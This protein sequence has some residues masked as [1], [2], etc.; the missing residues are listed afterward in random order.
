LSKDAQVI[1]SFIFFYLDLFITCLVVVL[2]G[3]GG[4]NHAKIEVLRIAFN[5][6]LG[7][8]DSILLQGKTKKKV[9][10]EAAQN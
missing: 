9:K 3:S 4:G 1:F 2:L 10:N 7:H 5:K 8:F 6:L